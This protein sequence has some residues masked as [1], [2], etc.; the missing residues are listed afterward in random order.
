MKGKRVGSFQNRGPL[1]T[2]LSPEL[3]LEI[4][5]VKLPVIKLSGRHDG[6][7]LSKVGSQKMDSLF[8]IK[9]WKP[10][11]GY[12]DFWSPKGRLSL[13]DSSFWFVESAIYE[14]SSICLVLHSATWVYYLVVNTTSWDCWCY[15]HLTRKTHLRLK[16]M[17]SYSRRQILALSPGLAESRAFNSWPLRFTASWSGHTFIHMLSPVTLIYFNF[18]ML[19]D[20]LTK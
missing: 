17:R 19:V 16:S 1:H 9:S 14:A 5:Y 20:F 4:P 2:F 18:F 15:S 8:G 10:K 3:T 13:R 6:L 7:V 11:P 12:W